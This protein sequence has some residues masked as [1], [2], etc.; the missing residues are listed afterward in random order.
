MDYGKSFTFVFEDDNWISKFAIGVLITLIPIVNFASYGYVIQ[1]LQNVRDGQEHPL[2]E[3]D[4]FGKYFI[5]GLKF[6]AG[7][8]VYFIPV[9]MLSFV[10][11][12]FAFAAE[13]MGGSEDVLA[14]GM[15]LITCVVMLFTFLPLLLYPALYIQFAKDDK[16]GD[17]FR[18]GEMWDLFK[19]DPANYIIIM[20]MIFFVLSMIASFGMV[21]CFVG[22]FVTTWWTQLAGAHMLGQLA[23]PQEKAVTV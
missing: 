19:S 13:A 17:M 8:L 2:P 1:L 5:N 10:I 12:G 16:F 4:D 20:I 7:F 3:W 21:L 6:L 14:I 18:F 22:V 23:R 15:M 9:M 11:I